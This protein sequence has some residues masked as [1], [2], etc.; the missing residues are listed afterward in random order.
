[1][2]KTNLT[3]ESRMFFGLDVSCIPLLNLCTVPGNNT[4]MINSLYITHV[5]A[6]YLVFLVFQVSLFECSLFACSGIMIAVFCKTEKSQCGWNDLFFKPFNPW[7]LPNV[8]WHNCYFWV[9]TKRSKFLLMIC[10]RRHRVSRTI[11][12]NF[13]LISKFFNY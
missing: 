6:H 2:I 9:F 13:C 12:P 7:F 3:E 5:P 4:I 10:S 11:Q 8:K 1:M